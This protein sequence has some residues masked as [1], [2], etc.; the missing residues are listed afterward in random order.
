MKLVSTAKK[1]SNFY[2]YQWKLYMLTKLLFK[3]VKNTIRLIEVNLKN[4]AVKID[5]MK[6]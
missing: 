3:Q 1:F 6:S 2:Q 5:K 4:K